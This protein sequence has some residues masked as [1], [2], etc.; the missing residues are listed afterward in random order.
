M[1]T[2][3]FNYSEIS[4]HSLV[5]QCE[6]KLLP[7]ASSVHLENILIVRADSSVTETAPTC[8]QKLTST[9]NPSLSPLLPTLPFPIP[10]M[11][12]INYNNRAV[13][14]QMH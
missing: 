11:H 14:L 7:W 13:P 3:Q 8:L 2:K 1:Y 4:H 6:I 5:C 12:T 9:I 10:H